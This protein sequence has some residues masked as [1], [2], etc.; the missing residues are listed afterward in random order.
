M[1]AFLVRRRIIGSLYM[2]FTP[3]C[4]SFTLLWVPFYMCVCVLLW[5]HCLTVLVLVGGSAIQLSSLKDLEEQCVWALSLT[6]LSI[7]C[8]HRYQRT[9]V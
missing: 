6:M 7:R 8:S 1:V 4:D 9:L 5:L 3:A 2:A